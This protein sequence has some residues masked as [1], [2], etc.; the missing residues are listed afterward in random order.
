MKNKETDRREKGDFFLF[1]QK[2]GLFEILLKSTLY[3]RKEVM[4]LL[5]QKG[6]SLM[7]SRMLK[8]SHRYTPQS[9]FKIP[10]DEINEYVF[11]GID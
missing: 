3:Y 6:L 11:C 9:S 4:V 2:S 7:I 8:I 5:M 1:F 10:Q